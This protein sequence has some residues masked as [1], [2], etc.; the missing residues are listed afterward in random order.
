ME[1]RNS[2]KTPKAAPA[3]L[4]PFNVRF[5]ALYRERAGGSAHTFHL[6]PGSTVADLVSAVRTQFPGIAPASVEIVV[7]VNQEYAVHDQVLKQGDEIAL[8]PPVSGG[9]I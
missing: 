7:A 8:I 5:F 3:S 6:P 2:S 4:L 1:S 9:R